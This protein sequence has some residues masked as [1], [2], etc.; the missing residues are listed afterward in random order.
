[1]HWTISR[2]KQYE[3]CPRQYQWTHILKYPQVGVLAPAL[4]RGTAIHESIEAH[5]KHGTKLSPE[6]SPQW[7]HQLGV[8]K[9]DGCTSEE[10]WEFD[11]GWNPLLPDATL[12]LRMKIDAWQP[13]SPTVLTVIDFK[14]GKPWPA[15]MEQLEV[16][17]LGAFGR[18][19]AVQE[20]RAALWYLDDEEP[21]EKTFKREHAGKLAR[22]W[23]GRADRMLTDATFAPKPG[24]ACKWCP[25]RDRCDAAT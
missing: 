24:F 21:H 2:L 6:V 20:V 11:A 14:T 12:W 15:N 9:Q 3:S 16:Y 25:Y 4:V 13:T 10:M 18:Y 19:D 23:E 22:K 8:L 5:L 7:A 1:M 17:A